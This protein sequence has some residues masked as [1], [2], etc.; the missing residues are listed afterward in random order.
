MDTQLLTIKEQKPQDIPK[1]SGNWLD[2]DDWYEL[3]H[4]ALGSNCWLSITESTHEH[5]TWQE[6][7]V[8]NNIYYQLITATA[9]SQ[10]ENIVKEFE[11]TEDSTA[12]TNS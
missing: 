9:K 7:K 11:T 6:Q 10:I 3:G 4:S 8:N 2:W 1:C 12:L 5:L